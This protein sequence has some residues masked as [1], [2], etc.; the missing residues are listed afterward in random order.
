VTI[1][2][3]PAPVLS[4]SDTQTNL[5]APLG[6]EYRID[7]PQ[8]VMNGILLPD[9]LLVVDPAVPQ[10]VR[11]GDGSALAINQANTLNSPANPARVG[12]FVS[13]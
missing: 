9:I 11:P 2:G 6:C 12:S 8:R 5:V 10:V 3:T 4:V 13:I 7:V 1:K